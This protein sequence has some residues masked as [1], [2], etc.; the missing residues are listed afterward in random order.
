MASCKDGNGQLLHFTTKYF[1]FEN[2]IKHTEN[3]IDTYPLFNECDKSSPQII[4]RECFQNSLTK[5]FYQSLKHQTFT[6][7]EPVLDTIWLTGV[8]DSNGKVVLNS[9]LCS[10]KTRLLLPTIDSI[11]EAK[12][13]SFPLATPAE[14][15]GMP[16]AI[17][18]Q[19]PLIINVN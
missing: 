18:F 5:L 13:Q 10:E 2:K 8:V 16:I 14:K 6:V 19:I 7:T 3:E 4:Q 15:D 1:S 12:I 11:I 9:T 17:Q